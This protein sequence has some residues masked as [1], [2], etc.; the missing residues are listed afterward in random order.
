MTRPAHFNDTHGDER[1][2]WLDGLCREAQA[3]QVGGMELIVLAF[4]VVFAVAIGVLFA[5]WMTGEHFVG[6]TIR[7]WRGQA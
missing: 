3:E 6:E 4:G 2:A 7:A 1:R 5:D